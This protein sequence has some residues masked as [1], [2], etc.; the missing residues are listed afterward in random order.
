MTTDIKITGAGGEYMESV[1]VVEWVVKPGD[2]VAAGNVVVVVETA[3]AAT[4]VEAPID[5]I[6]SEIVVNVGAEADIGAV[7]GRI[8]DGS[9]PFDTAAE[10]VAEN[11][12]LVSVETS[13][14]AQDLP[15]DVPIEQP[16]NGRIL[17]TPLA[18]R[19]AAELSINLASVNGTGPKGRIKRR[20]VELVSAEPVASPAG[21]EQCVL[22]IPSV[23]SNVD[24]YD[25]FA[26]G[27]YE[28]RPHDSMR[29]MIA[30]RLAE[31]KQ[32]IPHFYL[33]AT[34]DLDSLIRL[35]TEINTSIP[36]DAD[37]RSA[38]KISINDF[39]IKAHA[40]ALSE[41]RDAN[42]SWS[43]SGMI[44]HHSVDVSV[45]VAIPGGLITP[46]I[47]N[48][49]T[50]PISTISL[51]MKDLASRAFERQLAPNEY[52]GGTTSISNLGMFGVEEFAAIINPPQA[53]ILAVGAGRRVAVVRDEIVD[54]ATQMTV[55]LSVDH[56]AVDGALGAELLQSFRRYIESPLDM[57]V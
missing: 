14:N 49:N 52:Q 45:A 57:L 36:K 51:E 47:R 33:K 2:P 26:P 12:A 54:V 53:T 1:T 17:A 56:R 3:K 37:G 55:T 18:R 27:S 22:T 25:Q 5:G 11:P 19:I 30:A 7:L 15:S 6:L 35:R 31:A 13:P 8:S 50:K 28:I 44:V 42:V 46:I 21:S 10:A 40:K 23:P 39:V 24:E 29:K 20:D 34:C 32:T 16:A 9:E 4:E 48:A 41:V 43:D 38:Y